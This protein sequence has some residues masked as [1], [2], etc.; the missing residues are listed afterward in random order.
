MKVAGKLPLPSVVPEG[1]ESAPPWVEE[2]ATLAPGTGT[3]PGPITW[4]TRFA[5]FPGSTGPVSGLKLTEKAC[6]AGGGVACW[7]TAGVGVGV[8]GFCVV[9][10]GGAVVVVVGG[11]SVVVVGG[12]VVVVVG[13]AS[14]VVVGGAVVVVIVVGGGETMIVWGVA[15]VD[16][17]GM[18]GV[19]EGFP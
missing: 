10:V 5:G 8:L 3:L 11:A 1:G 19:I 4:I 16:I 7:D 2:R 6:G 9:V 14:V 13:G 18:V 15:S 17:A 12:A